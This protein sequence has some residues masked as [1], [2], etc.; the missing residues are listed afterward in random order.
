MRSLKLPKCCCNTT[1]RPEKWACL[2][3]TT[4]EG[5]SQVS[6]DCQFRLAWASR[7]RD[8]EQ[9]RKHL[10]PVFFQNLQSSHFG[11]L[12]VAINLN[13]KTSRGLGMSVFPSG[14]GNRLCQWE[15]LTMNESCEIK[16]RKSIMPSVLA[17][18]W[19]TTYALDATLPELIFLAALGKRTNLFCDLSGAF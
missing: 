5:T 4:W 8:H 12:Q 14:K 1:Y 3:D 18:A 15:T 16:Y 19:L 17:H 11:N 10:R 13:V 9:K 2:V 7:K 6:R